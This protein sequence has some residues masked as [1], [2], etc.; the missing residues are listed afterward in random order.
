MNVRCAVIGAA[1]AGLLASCARE[2]PPGVTVLTYASQYSPAHPFSRAD[3]AWM[4]WI[5]QRSGGRPAGAALLGRARCCRRN[6][7]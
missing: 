4:E 5:A 6:I 7:P 2:V 3:I 1:L